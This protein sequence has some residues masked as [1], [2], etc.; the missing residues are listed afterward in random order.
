MRPAAQAW[1]KDYSHRLQEV[2]RGLYNPVVFFNKATEL[3]LVVHGDDFTF[4]GYENDLDE[5]EAKM[6]SWYI[7]VRG[8]LVN[9]LTS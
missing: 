3:R 7:K 1:E 4:L 5:I 6:S 9:S 2:E 8:R